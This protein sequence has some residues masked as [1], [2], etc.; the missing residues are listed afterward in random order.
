MSWQL[1]PLKPVPDRRRT[2]TPRRRSTRAELQVPVM[3]KW[4][5]QDGSSK[6]E[7]T[8]TK[9]VN[10]R[11]CLLLL[12]GAVSEGVDV[13]IINRDSNEARKGRVVWSGEAIAVG[14]NRI[15]IELEDPD[16]RFWGNRY[17]DFLLWTTLEENQLGR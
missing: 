7:T 10:A 11:G 8:E 12:K 4:V 2:P 16:P 1:P 13:E 9:V 15:G 5:A 3:I 14:R 17:V 6:E